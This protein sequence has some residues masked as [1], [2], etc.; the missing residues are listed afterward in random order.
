MT[1]FTP[2]KPLTELAS[3]SVSHSS[4]GDLHTVLQ[5][6]SLTSVTLVDCDL[7][8]SFFRSF[9]RERS[10]VSLSLID[11][12]LDSTANLE[13]FEGLTT[14]T[15]VRSGEELDWSRLSGLPVLKTVTIDGSMEAAVRPALEGTDVE[16][17]MLE[18]T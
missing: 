11:C 16:I 4:T 10:L 15:L 2:L 8:G 13:D 6:S 12:K 17:L 5:L 3:F 18:E 1:D 7:R 14:L 9:D